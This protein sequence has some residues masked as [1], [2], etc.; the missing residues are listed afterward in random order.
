MLMK[1]ISFSKLVTQYWLHILAEIA[2]LKSIPD[3]HRSKITV[4][5]SERMP[6]TGSMGDDFV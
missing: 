6:I 4:Y 1:E 5:Q 2:I 3:T